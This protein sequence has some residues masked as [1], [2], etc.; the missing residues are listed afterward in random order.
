MWQIDLVIL[1]FSRLM[2]VQ[3]LTAEC[4]EAVT[5]L[6][7]GSELSQCLQVNNLLPSKFHPPS[8]PDEESN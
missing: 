5:G 6:V 8:H 2:R 1:T 3:R 7:T 4:R